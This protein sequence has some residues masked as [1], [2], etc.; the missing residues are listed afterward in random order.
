MS[1]ELFEI[2]RVFGGLFEFAVLIGFIYLYFVFRSK[3]KTT[4]VKAYKFLSLGFG[5]SVLSIL[6]PT[7]AIFI[8]SILVGD[9][10]VDQL[11]IFNDIPYYLTTTLSIMF[12]IFAAKKAEL[13]T[14]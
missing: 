9:D 6:I 2:D 7:V 10:F 12:F 3:S 1:H 5:F 14:I 13:K 11:F 4:G 8:G